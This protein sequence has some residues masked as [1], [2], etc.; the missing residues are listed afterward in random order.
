MISGALISAI[1]LLLTFPYWEI[2]DHY[3][4]TSP[5]S[6][7]A[8]L[9]LPLFLSYTYPELDHYSPTR[10]DTTTILG[11]GAGCS[12][13]YWLNERLGQTFEPRGPL[14]APLPALT[15]NTLASGVARFLL[16][17]AALV[18]TRQ[19]VKAASLEVLHCWHRVP[20]GDA[21]ARTRREIEVPY[22]FATYTAVGLV[23]SI[24]VNR[25]F[26]LLGL[27]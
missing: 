8:A 19:I 7:V 14:P 18:A 20:K 5:V 4:L 12:V 1:L 21:G 26:I 23:N 3:Q 10:G 11:V 17:V 27:L 6:P 24:L 16:G 25:V 13:G 2:F 15:A 9:A 22:K